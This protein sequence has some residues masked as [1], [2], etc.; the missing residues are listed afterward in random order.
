MKTEITLPDELHKDTAALVVRFAQALAVKLRKAEVKHGY[1]TDW[2]RDD[3]EEKCHEDMLEHL[4]KGDPLDVAAYCA[5]MW[6]HMWGTEFEIH[7][8]LQRKPRPLPALTTTPPPD[9]P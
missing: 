9:H 2:Q 6:F 5:F 8:Y 7:S 4:Q 1:S 3:W